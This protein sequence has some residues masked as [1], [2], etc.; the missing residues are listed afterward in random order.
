M[1][2]REFITLV[3]GTVAAW[4]VCARAQQSE[5]I[6]R[7][8]LLMNTAADSPEA[9]PR[10][11][12]FQQGLEQLGWSDGR[13]V[14]IDIRWGANDAELDRRYAAELISLAPD[15]VVAAG[16]LGVAALQRITH[17]LPILFCR[18]WLCG[19]L[20]EA[21]RECNRVCAV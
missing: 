14:R 13:T 10:L 17:T 4:P 1:R 11:S 16:T 20:G 8:G 19:Q 2:R 15:L 7:V 6:R 12:A 5:Q 18:C 21:R 9:Q 3:G